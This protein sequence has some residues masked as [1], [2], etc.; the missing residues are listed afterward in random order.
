MDIRA[1]G[2]CPL[3]TYMKVEDIDPL[4]VKRETDSMNMCMKVKSLREF[5]YSLSESIDDVKNIFGIEN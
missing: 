5:I 3:A 1:R 4:F 2:L